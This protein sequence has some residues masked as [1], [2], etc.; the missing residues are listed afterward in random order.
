M[1]TD[2]DASDRLPA[3]IYRRLEG[4]RGRQGWWPGETPFEVVVGAVLTQNTAWTNVEKAIAALKD[5][6]ALDPWTIMD[7][8]HDALAALIRPAGYFNVKARRLK[9]V[10]S[11]L[12]DEVAGDVPA[13]GLLDLDD[14]RRRLL[15]VHGVGKETADSI[16]LYALEKPSFVVDAYTRRIF[17]RLGVLDPRADYDEIRAFFQK[18]LRRDVDLYNDYHAQI[19]IHGKLVC[20]ARPLCSDCVLADLCAA[21]SAGDG[22]HG[23]D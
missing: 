17:G 6:G 23:H 9:A 14:A 16:L 5:A 12:I 1:T 8:D 20:R 3:E 15:A 2:T 18:T 21:D 11:F 13:L 22:A 10:V 4:S 7:M 19:V